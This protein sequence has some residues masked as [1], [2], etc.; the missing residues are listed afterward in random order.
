[1]ADLR[2]PVLCRSATQKR[3]LQ[4]AAKAR[5]L[6]LGPW[7]LSLGLRQAA[8]EPKAPHASNDGVLGDQVV[9]QDTT[10]LPGDELV[11]LKPLF[12]AGLLKRR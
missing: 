6:K 5:G 9:A 8:G 7:L 3:T 12:E 2:I 10:G 4:R 1:M 11:D